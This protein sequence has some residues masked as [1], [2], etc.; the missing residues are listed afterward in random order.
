MKPLEKLY[1][2]RLALGMVAAI[3]CVGYGIA[4]EA[5]TSDITKMKFT[6][7]LNSMSLAIIVYLISYP[8]IKRKFILHVE[9]PQKLYTTGIGIYFLSWLVLWTLLFTM[10]AGPPLKYSL[11]ITTTSGGTTEPIPGT[12]NLLS[13]T[14]V[15]V[16]A[17]PDTNYVLDH[18]ELDGT[19]LG[20]SNPVSFTMDKNYTLHAVFVYSPPG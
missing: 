13:G 18:W 3:V 11:T 2:L 9:K 19:N 14:S 8:I 7:F 5:I 4:T 15:S 10:I 16:K 6:T 17:T 12:Y 20:T 1:W